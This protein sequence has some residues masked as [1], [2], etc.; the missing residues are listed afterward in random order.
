MY[1]DDF[2][3]T[4]KVTDTKI[5]TSYFN[6]LAENPQRTDTKLYFSF[7]FDFRRMTFDG[8]YVKYLSLSIIEVDEF[9]SSLKE[10]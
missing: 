2:I 6:S 4:T 5:T 1:F 7:F 3:P 10:T 9:I 8:E